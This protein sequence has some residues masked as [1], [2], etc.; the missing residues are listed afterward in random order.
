[1]A[2]VARAV[3]TRAQKVLTGNRFASSSS[4]LVKIE[5][6]DGIAIVSLNRPDKLNALNMEMFRGI[7]R[8]TKELQQDRDVSAVIVRGEGR[9]FCAGLDFKNVLADPLSFQKNFNDLMDRVPEDSVTNLA[10]AVGYEWRKIPAPVICVTHGVCIGGGLQIALGADFRYTTKDCQFSIMESKWGLIPDMSISVTL[11]E[12][13]SIDVA[14][15]LTMT[16]RKFGGEEAKQL[17]IVTKVCEDP[18]A[19]A[20]ALAKEIALVSPDAVAATKRLFN[21]TY[22]LNDQEALLLETD[23]QRQ[24]IM[25]WN[26][27]ASVAKGFGVPDFLAPTKTKRNDFWHKNLDC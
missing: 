21:K 9:A 25:G 6:K 19:D 2:R 18:M 7:V 22:A 4:E 12:L 13:V 24:L 27:V 1:M 17:G 15:E 26:N 10:Q 14:K 3:Q 8:I 20:L 5:R 16:H 11:R 23:L